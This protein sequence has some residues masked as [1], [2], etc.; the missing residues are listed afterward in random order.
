MCDTDVSDPYRLAEF[1]YWSRKCTCKSLE[2][3]PLDQ[4]NAPSIV[5]EE[6]ETMNVSSSRQT[7]DPQHREL[8]GHLNADVKRIGV[9]VCVEVR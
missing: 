7:I 8:L 2:Q 4:E 9:V 6:N 5:G 3:S 1:V